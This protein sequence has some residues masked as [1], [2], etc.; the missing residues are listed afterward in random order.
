MLI[1]SDDVK[2]VAEREGDRGRKGRR[3]SDGGKE[4][5]KKIRFEDDIEAKHWMWLWAQGTAWWRVYQKPMEC[6]KEL[7]F[8]RNHEV[9]LPKM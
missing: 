5:K 4:G 1:V 6:L 8:Q 3:E 7:C 9:R 2:V